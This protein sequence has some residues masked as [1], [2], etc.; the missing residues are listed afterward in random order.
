MNHAFEEKEFATKS[1]NLTL[2]KRIFKELGQYRKNLILVLIIS[3]F[4]AM[5]DVIFPFLNKYAIDN[6]IVEKGSTKAIIIFI[7]VYFILIIAQGLFVFSFINECGKIEC[8]FAYEVRKKAFNKIQELSF[9]YFDVTPV[10]WIMARMTSDVQKLAEI[11]SWSILDIVWGSTL[12]LGISVVMIIVNIKLALIV[13]ATIP[14]LAFLAVY[15]EKRILNSYRGV[16]KINSKITGAFNEGINGA[17]TTKTL[18]LEEYNEK[19]FNELTTS[20]KS[21]SIKAAIFSSLLLPLVTGLGSIASAYIIYI[22]GKAVLLK[23][24]EFGTLVLFTQYATQFFDPLRQISRLMAEMQMAQ[25]SAERV[26]HLLDSKAN[27]SEK[28]EVKIKYGDILEPKR[29]RFKKILGNVEFKHVDFQY[30]E[31]EIVLKDFNLKVAQG[32]KIALVGETGS[33]KSTIVNLLCRFYEPTSGS[34]Y[35]DGIDY[36]NISLSNLHSSLGYVLQSPHLFSGSIAENIRFGKKDA[37]DEEIINV[38]KMIGIHDHI[39]KLD[40]QYQ[41][42]VGEGGSKLSTG[43]KQLIS[44][45]RAVIGNPRLIILDEAT[46]SIDTESEKLVQDAIKNILKDRTSFIVAHRLSTITSCDKI[47]VLKNGKVIE[48]GKHED[49]LNKK[50]YYYQLYTNQFAEQNNF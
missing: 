5:C 22:G 3:F 17:R 18:A 8:G 42:E 45:A 44:F 21:T 9:S 20:M 2:W 34:I 40:H 49:L 29:E 41:S 28:E 47:L 25:A 46:S 7:I 26:I 6:F 35:I 50:G 4:V 13:F 12:I 19:E 30:I 16:R 43:E 36:R 48:I 37:T 15:F 10:G 1:F 24:L 14:F 27:I 31:N 33:G 32:E 11:L 38:C 23:T 39:I